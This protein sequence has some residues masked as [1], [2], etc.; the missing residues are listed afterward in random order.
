MLIGD[1]LYIIMADGF[2]IQ[3]MAGFGFPG[4]SG[5][6]RGVSGEWETNIL[7]GRPCPRLEPL[8]APVMLIFGGRLYLPLI[9]SAQ[10]FIVTSY[11]VRD[12][13][14]FFRALRSFGTLMY[15][16]K[17]GFLLARESNE[18]DLSYNLQFRRCILFHH[19]RELLVDLVIINVDLKD[20]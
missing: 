13:L 10:I 8:L 15:T 7:G 5:L 16:K 14:P 3:R 4:L 12:S 17:G 6:R 18:F 1:G 2:E 19:A 9:L 20:M 11:R